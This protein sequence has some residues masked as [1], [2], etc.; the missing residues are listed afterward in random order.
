MTLA[1]R[2]SS[3]FKNLLK[4]TGAQFA[5]HAEGYRFDQDEIHIF[6]EFRHAR[7]GGSDDDL[8][9]AEVLVGAGFLEDVQPVHPGKV[10]IE[11]H[12]LALQRLAGA[13]SLGF[14]AGGG[15]R[16]G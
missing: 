2:G 9:F 13:D 5:Q 1:W 8:D 14:V 6:D 16:T 3:L 4:Q 12:Q 15:E 10:K 11:H 7:V